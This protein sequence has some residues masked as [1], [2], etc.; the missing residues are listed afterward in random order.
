M[1]AALTQHALHLEVDG[2]A[3]GDPDE[4]YVFDLRGRL[5]TARR[6]DEHVRLGLSGE[7][8]ARRGAR[9]RP[10]RLAPATREAVL[11]RARGCALVAGDLLARG[12]LAGEV[13]RPGLVAALERARRWD[14]AAYAAHAARFAATYRA[15]RILPPDCQQALLVQLTEGCSHG[16]CT[17]CTLYED[18]P[19]RAKDAPALAGHLERV[20][21]LLGVAASL[22]DRVFL[23]DAN[24][25]LLPTGRLLAAMEAVAARFAEP[26]RGG[27][28]AFVDAFTPPGK[29]ARE[30]AALR[31]AGLRRV[32]LGL[33]SG[34]A[35]LL[36]WLD[37]PGGPAAAAGLVRAAKEAGL[38]VGLV[39]LVGAG[40]A[41][42]ARA[43]VEETLALVSGLP[44][45]RRDLVFLSPLVVHPGGRYAR[46]AADEGLTPLAPTE[47]AAQT[48]A[49]RAGL[50]PRRTAPY[51]LERWLY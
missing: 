24:A 44:L 1:R 6:G 27:F 16:R 25:L 50:R 37:K 11:E 21:A 46:R 41:R 8:Q 12:A 32:T 2:D 43:H 51:A 15:V 29:P 10:W 26:A 28:H 49:L 14:L 4:H 22:R 18:V 48:A 20:E 47:L 17:F 13:G 38:E 5:L 23:G 7:A 39:V 30:L 33:E 9:G 36:T 34:C 19:F 3:A 45:E 35:E 40:G 42:F 31:E